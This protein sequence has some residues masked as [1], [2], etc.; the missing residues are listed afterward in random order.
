MRLKILSL[1]IHKGFSLRQRFILPTL[2]E[3]LRT[4]GADIVFLQEVLGRHDGHASKIEDWPDQT[5]TEYLADQVWSDHAYGRNAIYEAGDHGNAIL[6]RW[7][8][9]EPVNTDISSSRHERRGILSS[10]FELAHQRIY[11][12]TLHLSLQVSSRRKQLT[13]L[14]EMVLT[15]IPPDAPLVIGGD[16]NDWTGE[17]GRYFAKELHLAEVCRHIHGIEAR[18]FPSFLP[19]L[20]L[21]RIYV[22]GLT[23]VSAQ[24]LSHSPWR[25]LS[26]H[27]PLLTELTDD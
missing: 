26:D 11:L 12:V 24:T 23:I 19:L 2:K 6:S 7:N 3:A 14:R 15:R 9:Q 25:E 18:T 8:L 20:R 5:Q 21:D 27:L 17:A 13:A 4:T 16:F 22:R 10:S 1:N